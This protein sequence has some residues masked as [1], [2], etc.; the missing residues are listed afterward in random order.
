[1]EVRSFGSILFQSHSLSDHS[2][3]FS[4]A[5]RLIREKNQPGAVE[6]RFR[7]ADL[8]HGVARW[9]CVQLVRD[10]PRKVDGD[11][12][13]ARA[14]RS[15]HLRSPGRSGNRRSGYGS[16]HAYRRRPLP[17]TESAVPGEITVRFRVLARRR[18]RTAVRFAV[19][20]GSAKRSCG[21]ERSTEC[22]TT[23]SSLLPNRAFTHFTTSASTRCRSARAFP[24]NGVSRF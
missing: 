1:M 4:G 13:L 15:A 3:R 8:L 2:P 9:V 22:A 10:C 18:L 14:P 7:S 20:G 6:N 12:S 16:R 17:G 11:P 19:L 24:A 21:S 5:N 23:R